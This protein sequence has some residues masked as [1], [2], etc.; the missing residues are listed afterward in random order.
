MTDPTAPAPGPFAPGVFTAPAD[1]GPPRLLG[2]RCAPCGRWFFPRPA[3]CPGCLER[4]E[5]AELGGDG[6]VYSCTVV[7]VRPPWGLPQPY[8]VGY[9]DLDGSGLR[10]FGLLDPAALDR[11]RVGVPVRLAVGP[12]GVDSQGTPCLRPYFSP[13]EGG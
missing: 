9:V 4:V 7:R 12:L 11:F 5:E 10:V 13:A 8:G 3:R 2:G 1:G 6:A